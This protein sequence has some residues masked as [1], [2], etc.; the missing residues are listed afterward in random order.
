[1]TEHF[2]VVIVGAGLAG[3]GAGYHLQKRCPARSYVILENRERIGGT[4]DL[5]RYP[6]VRSD[7]DMYTLGYAFRPWTG[8]K[9]IADGAS[10]RQY[11]GETAVEHGIDR[12]VRFSH[13][14]TQAAWSSQSK[15]WTLTVLRGPGEER[16][17]FTCS[18]LFSCSG[19]YRYDAGYT[20]EFPGSARFPGRIVHP[21][22]WPEDLD[23]AGKR[24]VVIGSG[25]TAVTLVPALASGGAAHVTMLQR[26]PTYMVLAPARDGTAHALRR[27]LPEKLAYDVVRWRNI[28]L[29]AMFFRLSRS[30]PRWV[31]KQLLKGIELQLGADYDREHWTP[32]YAPWDQRLCVVPDGD[33][34]TAIK[35]GTASIVTDHIETFTEQGIALK[36]GQELPADIIVTATGISLIP[37]GGIDITVDGK[38]FEPGQTLGY[39]G[40]LFR[41]LPNFASAFGYINASWTLKA[42]LAGRYVCRL[43]N[44]M[45][46]H[47][48]T[49]CTPRL[50]DPSVTTSQWWELS[51]G[52][53]ARSRDLLPKQ[54][55]KAPWKLHQNYVSDLFS[56]R[57]GTLEDGVL[58]FRA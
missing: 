28:L 16:V 55:S 39:K 37:L 36:S 6:G 1:M 9:A 41:D 21:Q 49:Q 44:Y 22:Q 58:E 46:K 14:V 15:R 32:R 10:I 26:S 4:W 7:S 3:I 43:L 35:D 17:E 47:G 42:E 51:S 2:D 20:P 18:F 25:A 53:V 54:G 52:Y 56:M 57:L 23:Y 38:P 11:V 40:V 27:K 31:A 45:H 24:V 50:N 13:R 5:F 33:L 19:Y 29:N 34:L 48:Y 30:A 12:H 8:E